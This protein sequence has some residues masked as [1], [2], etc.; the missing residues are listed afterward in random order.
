MG[1]IVSFARRAT[2]LL[3]LVLF[4]AIP[5]ITAA[6]AKEAQPDPREN[7]WKLLRSGLEDKKLSNRTV[8]VQAL[9][10]MPGNTR[11]ARFAVAALRDK[12]TG[13]RE[14]AAVVL[15]QQRARSAIPALKEAL[16]DS[17]ISVVLAAAHSLLLLKDSSAY[18]IYYAI[19]MGDKKGS[20]GLVESQ[21]NR[22]K[23]P[24]QLAEMGIS[25]GVGFV[26]FGG[27]GYE[28]YRQIRKHDSSPVRA[29]AA[30]FLAND[31]DA[32]SED[33][34]VQ[35]AVADKEEEVRLA[36]LDALAQRGDPRCIERLVKNLDGSKPAVRYRTAAVILH[37]S[38]IAKKPRK[39]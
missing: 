22:F 21:I 32:M 9:S 28:A 3:T 30:R 15:G 12:S 35:T 10:L 7:A 1:G 20:T 8:A 17:E 23:D 38:D 13:V 37:L 36:A 25:E 5:T 16:S 31:P 14:A 19:L 33:A 11:A 26:P 6:N 34:L 39:R 29:A 18:E 2:S 24:K 27:M 4:S